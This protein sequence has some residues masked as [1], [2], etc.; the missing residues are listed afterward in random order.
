M[1]RS[2]G[3]PGRG[4]NWVYLSRELLGDVLTVLDAEVAAAR[5]DLG[6]SGSFAGKALLFFGIAASILIWI[7]AIVGYVMVRVLALW[8]PDWGAGLIVLGFFL[9]LAGILGA[10]G[11]AKVKRVENPVD[12]VTRR[13]R[14]HLGWW[15][16]DVALHTGPVG[17]ASEEQ[18]AQEEGR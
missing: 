10:I 11:Y 13:L 7:P 8:L 12:T 14:S 1:S 3:E 15:R 18:A 5:S 9:L 16:S 6:T 17:V 4:G 2:P